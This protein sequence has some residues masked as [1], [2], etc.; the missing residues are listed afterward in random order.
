MADIRESPMGA[1]VNIPSRRWANR[2]HPV[3]IRKKSGG[4]RHL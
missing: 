1:D 4:F 3:A 2:N